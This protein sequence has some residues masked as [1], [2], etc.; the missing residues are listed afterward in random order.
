MAS[1]A[2]FKD[3]LAG[4]GVTSMGSSAETKGHR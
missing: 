1:L 3:F 4:D 2:F